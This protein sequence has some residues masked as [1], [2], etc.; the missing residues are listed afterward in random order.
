MISRPIIALLA[1][2]LSAEGAAAGIVG[3][4]GHAQVVAAPPSVVPPAFAEDGV[5]HVFVE[6][7]DVPLPMDVTVDMTTHFSG[8]DPLVGRS[9]GT[10][11]MGTV[12][13]SYYVHYDPTGGGEVLGSV[14]FAEPILGVIAEGDESC[15]Q[16][17]V[18]PPGDTLGPSNVLGAPGTLYPDGI[19]K[20]GIEDKPDKLT[21]YPATLSFALAASRPGDRIRV[22][23]AATGS[24]IPPSPPELPIGG[25]KLV[26]RDK[27]GDPSKR[28]LQFEARD[29]LVDS[30]REDPTAVASF[31][32]VYSATDSACIA[33]GAGQW[34]SEGT[35]YGYRDSAHASGACT[36]GRWKPGEI[37]MRCKGAGIGFSLDE[38]SQGTVHV[39]FGTG[40]LRYC[41][42][43]APPSVTQ[44]VVGRFQ[45]RAAEPGACVPPPSACP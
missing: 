36:V 22:L 43:F 30:A 34:T 27:L 3:T 1:V 12:V 4:T 24:P 16:A 11:P 40:S 2:A 25:R 29:L 42:A 37:R 13:S 7:T 14:S 35:W 19:N 31:L 17:T 33:L 38:P 9:L 20:L 23:T 28:F 41:V 18:D 6:Q 32:H 8:Y 15:C 39:A 21:L 10:I 5:V 44:D 45:A 26:L